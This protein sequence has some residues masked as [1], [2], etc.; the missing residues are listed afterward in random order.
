MAVDHT[1][2]L[3]KSLE[4]LIEKRRALS[5]RDAMSDRD[6]GFSERII[7]LQNAIAATLQAIAE[8]EAMPVTVPEEA[9][10]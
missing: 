2:P 3:K 5:R 1:K 9:S 10:A 6:E 4:K 8:E 7:I